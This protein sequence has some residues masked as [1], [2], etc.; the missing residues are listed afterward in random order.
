MSGICGLLRLD[1]RPV[2]ITDLDAMLAPMHRRGPD[3][4]STWHHGPLGLGHA[5]LATTPEAHAAPQP[6]VCPDSGCVVVADSRLDERAPLA[7][8]L[9]LR[10]RPSD[11]IGDAELIAAAWQRW[12]EA[13]T[14]HLTGDFA[15]VAWDPRTHT[16]HCA[17]DITGVRPLYVSFVPGRLLA[18][19]S[20]T[21]ALLAL[22]DVPDTLNPP[23]LADALADFYESIDPRIT[24]HAAIERLPPATTLTLRDG[25]R[26]ERKYWHPL[27]RRPALPGS[28]G[29][30]IEATRHVLDQAVRRRL[31]GGPA[32]AMV[33]GGLDSSSVAALAFRHGQHLGGA[34]LRTYSAVDSRAANR[35]TNAIGSMLQAYP[36]NA[37][38]VDLAHPETF[39]PAVRAQHDAARE[40]FDAGMTLLSAIYATAHRDGVRVMLD[41]MPGDALYSSSRLLAYL[42]THAGWKAAWHEAVAMHREDQHHHPHLRAIRTLASNGLPAW[43]K[44]MLARRHHLRFYR[45][46]VW[47]NAA[48]S[49]HF[50]AQIG[51]RER[52]TAFFEHL[53]A[54]RQ[55][56][57][58]GWGESIMAAGH[59][60]AGAERYGRIASHHGIEPRHP[61]LDRD[62]IEL[63][64]W[65]PPTLRIR[66]GRHKWALR[67]AMAPLLPGD[68]AWRKDKDHLGWAF[69]MLAY[70]SWPLPADTLPRPDAALDQWIAPDALAWVRS[71]RSSGQTVTQR[72]GAALRTAQWLSRMPPPERAI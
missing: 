27:Q 32:G 69:N 37:T 60:A 44:R 19:A 48:I 12:G 49:S 25:Q 53:S 58:T 68:I 51:L 16:L 36:F 31:R 21:H 64:A 23:R 9:G 13:C 55:V 33:S 65:M 72:L 8:A 50:A 10:D 35:E 70:A 43:A 41:G 15:F 14:A 30:W 63:H 39:L 29:E 6:W 26:H 2:A 17:R 1:G 59:I 52:N 4:H 5:L 45:D 18:F 62:V 24:F 40:P 54:T 46:T 3:G 28:E 47:P 38:R 42:V 20:D 7:R 56:D 61:F 71:E 57:A 66:D 11:Q 67:Q 34:P 22:P